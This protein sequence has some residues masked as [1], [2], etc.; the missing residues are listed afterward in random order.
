LVEGFGSVDGSD[1]VGGPDFVQVY[2]DIL[3]INTSFVL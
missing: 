1:S 2:W 3:V